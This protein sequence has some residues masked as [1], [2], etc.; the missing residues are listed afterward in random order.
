MSVILALGFASSED[1][2]ADCFA[3]GDG[4][5]VETNHGTAH[6]EPVT[7]LG[8]VERTVGEDAAADFLVVLVERFDGFEV[9]IDDDV[10]QAVEQEGHTVGGE[11]W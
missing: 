9:A 2:A 1:E 4:Q 7:L 6:V 10:E 3:E 8:R 11:V 5:A